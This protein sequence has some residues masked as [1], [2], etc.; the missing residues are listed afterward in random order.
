M[1]FGRLIEAP[2]AMLLPSYLHK[3]RAAKKAWESA[4]RPATS[5]G[6]IDDVPGKRLGSREES[7]SVRC[8]TVPEN[9]MAAESLDP[10][11]RRHLHRFADVDRPEDLAIWERVR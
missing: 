5:N 1:F 3:N 7:R 2:T 4:T 8:E 10:S 6:S 9:N 11:R